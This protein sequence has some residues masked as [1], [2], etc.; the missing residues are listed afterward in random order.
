MFCVCTNIFAAQEAKECSITIGSMYVF[1]YVW[2]SKCVVITTLFRYRVYLLPGR[3]AKKAKVEVIVIESCNCN[4]CLIIGHQAGKFWFGF[5]FGGPI[6][7]SPKLVGKFSFV[8]LL[9]VGA[10]Y[11]WSSSSSFGCI[12]AEC[13]NKRKQKHTIS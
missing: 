7:C 11:L 5:H 10:A 2:F 9:L 8:L 13:S 1:P 4:W 12:Y 3:F 6:G